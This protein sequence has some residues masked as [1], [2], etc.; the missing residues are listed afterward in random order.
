MDKPAKILVLLVSIILVLYRIF[1]IVVFDI[2]YSLDC[3][4]TTEDCDKAELEEGGQIVDV[5]KNPIGRLCQQLCRTRRENGIIL[6]DYLKIDPVFSKLT[7]HNRIIIGSYA[8]IITPGLIIAL[9]LLIRQRRAGLIIAYQLW[10]IMILC[11][12]L[13]TAQWL[14]ASIPFKHLKVLIIVNILDYFI[15]LWVF[16]ICHILQHEREKIKHF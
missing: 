14:L 8:F 3:P 2:P 5:L 13:I 15:P 1:A 6:D 11:M 10:P 9:F 12:T 16:L 7:L 4:L